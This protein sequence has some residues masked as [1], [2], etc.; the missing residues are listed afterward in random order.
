[1]NYIDISS[2]VFIDKDDLI[3]ILDLDKTTVSK[4][5]R[6]FLRKN[7]KNKNIISTA[8]DIPK[9]IVVTDDKIYLAQLSVVSLKGKL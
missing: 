2:K 7:E 3:C 8:N 9:S 5:T 6:E 1:M 4:I